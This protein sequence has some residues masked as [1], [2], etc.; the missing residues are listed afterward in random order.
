MN[1]KHKQLMLAFLA[2]A[3][4]TLA[5]TSS[6]FIIQ[7]QKLSNLIK[8]QDKLWKELNDFKVNNLSHDEFLTR[9]VQNIL[10]NNPVLNLFEDNFSKVQTKINNL[11]FALNKFKE[12]INKQKQLNFEKYKTLSQEVETYISKNLKY[13]EYEDLKKSLENIKLNTDRH[14]NYESTQQEIDEQVKILKEAFEK[15]KKD[16]AIKDNDIRQIAYADYEMELRKLN[17]FIKNPLAQHEFYKE[18]YDSEIINRD[19]ITKDIDLNTSSVGDILEAKYKLIKELE[20]A[21]KKAHKVSKQELQ[22]TYDKAIKYANGTLI[23]PDDENTKNLL[24]NNAKEKHDSGMETD[25]FNII[26]ENI[27]SILN[28][29]EAAKIEKQVNDTFR[30]NATNSL[31]TAIKLAEDFIE[32]FS[33]GKY[34]EIKKYVLDILETET[35]DINPKTFDQI[36]ESGNKIVDALEAKKTEAIASYDAQVKKINEIKNELSIR[37]YYSIRNEISQLINDQKTIR[38]DKNSTTRQILDLTEALKNYEAKIKNKKEAKLGID[39]IL[40]EIEEYI[41]QNNHPEDKSSIAKLQTKLNETKSAIENLTKASELQKFSNEL[42]TKFEEIKQKIE[43]TKE[44]RESENNSYNQVVNLVNNLL[45]KLDS[46]NNYLDLKQQLSTTKT[47]TDGVVAK[48]DAISTS[49]QIKEAKDKLETKLNE[50]DSKKDQ[51]DL[52]E[53]T[54]EYNKRVAE[55]ETYKNSLDDKHSVIKQNLESKINKIKA[56]L[57]TIIDNNKETK[58][59]K[60]KATQQASS[61]IQEA[62]NKA[63]E[64]KEKTNKNRKFREFETLKNAINDY[65]DINLANNNDFDFIKDP[66]TKSVK[67]ESKLVEKDPNADLLQLKDK[68]EVEDIQK[69]I[70]KLNEIFNTS[71]DLK[72]SKDNYDNQVKSAE[73]KLSEIQKPI[74]NKDDEELYNT[75]KNKVTELQKFFEDDNNKTKENFDSKAQELSKA[76]TKTTEEYST[77]KAKRDQAKVKLEDKIKEIEDYVKNNLQE[78]KNGTFVTKPEHEDSVSRI[79]LK[80]QIAKGVKE[81]SSSTEQQL[82][83]ALNELIKEQEILNESVK[84]DNTAKQATEFLITLDKDL[85]A[86]I[87]NLQRSL[88][89]DLKVNLDSAIELQKSNKTKQDVTQKSI[90][91]AKEDLTNALNDAKNKEFNIFQNAYDNLSKKASELL[92]KLDETNVEDINKHTQYPEIAKALKEIKDQEDAKALSNS[93]PTIEIIKESLPKLQQAYD[94]AI[95]AKSKSDFDKVYEDILNKFIDNKNTSKYEKVKESVISKLKAQKDIRDKENPVS[96]SQEIDNATEIIKSQIP[97]LNSIK[98]KFDEYI[99]KYNKV[100]DYKKKLSDDQEEAKK[101]LADALETYKQS[102]ISNDDILNPE[103]YKEFKDKLQEAI[104]NAKI[105]ETSKNNYKTEKDSIVADS[106]FN[107]YPKSL[108]KYKDAVDKITGEN[109]SLKQALAAAKT[110][111]EIKQAY[112]DAK[113][114][115]KQAKNDIALNKAEENYLNIVDKIDEF[116]KQLNSKDTNEK[117]IID[118]LDKAKKDAKEAINNKTS[119]N[120]SSITTKDYNTQKQ[121][122][123]EA[124]LKAQLDKSKNDFKKTKQQAQATSNELEGNYPETKAY[125]DNKLSEIDGELTT[126]LTEAGK[127]IQKQKESYDTAKKAIE[128][129]N[130]TLDTKKHAELEK[131]KTEYEKS[132]TKFNEINEQINDIKDDDLKQKYTKEFKEAKSE[133]DKTLVDPKTPVKYAKAKEIL[134]AASESIKEYN[135]YEKLSKEVG[136]YVNQTL[137]NPNYKDL[138][139]ELAIAKN[140]QDNVALPEHNPTI[141]QVESSFDTLNEKYNEVK[142]SILRRN[143]VIHQ[144]TTAKTVFNSTKTE[145]TKIFGDL[146]TINKVIEF[147]DSNSLT[148]DNKLSE[149]MQ[150]HSHT[151]KTL[152][153]QTFI[154]ARNSYSKLQ[155]DS[156][157]ELRKQ[158]IAVIDEILNEPENERIDESKEEYKNLDYLK[159]KISAVDYEKSNYQT[160]IKS[161]YNDVQQNLQKINDNKKEYEKEHALALENLNKQNE[162]KNSLV[163]AK[164]TLIDAPDTWGRSLKYVNSKVNNTQSDKYLLKKDKQQFEGE[165]TAVNNKINFLQTLINKK[166]IK[167]NQTAKNYSSKSNLNLEENLNSLVEDVKKFIEITEMNNNENGYKNRTDNH[168]QI[169]DVQR[170]DET[171]N[172]YSDLT[173]KFIAKYEKQNKQSLT[174]SDYVNYRNLFFNSVKY[175]EQ[176]MD[177]LKNKLKLYVGYNE[178]NKPGLYVQK[179]RKLYGYLPLLASYKVWSKRL[180]G[181][182]SHLYKAVNA[183]MNFDDFSIPKPENKHENLT[184]SYLKKLI[185]DLQKSDDDSSDKKVEE[186][187]EQFIKE[188][189]SKA[190]NLIS[191]W[192]NG[193]DIGH[194]SQYYWKNYRWN[195]LRFKGDSQHYV[196]NEYVRKMIYSLLY[197]LPKNIENTDLYIKIKQQTDNL[198]RTYDQN[199]DNSHHTDFWTHQTKINNAIETYFELIDKYYDSSNTKEYKQLLLWDAKGGEAK[200]TNIATTVDYYADYNDGKYGFR[201]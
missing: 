105:V 60:I 104:N 153:D 22:I 64:E 32:S 135:K 118:V 144:L 59:E 119:T 196:F 2:I 201:L 85:N 190:G 46:K 186:N 151:N 175:Y 148:I 102:N 25:D 192:Y 74:L 94:A 37:N 197:K 8:E 143:V 69:S 195:Y 14:V 99:N 11:K 78:N 36:Y 10:D 13:K 86:N 181:F 194:Y 128:N 159:T 183:Y 35:K 189:K 182:Y 56:D 82:K 178:Q 154:E 136:D 1:R 52:D 87:T 27:N 168:I 42:N 110:T 76:I 146:K 100:S 140:T 184:F 89:S 4:T 20:D 120:P 157:N 96:T 112:E 65:I 57:Q 38:N 84:F 17:D 95:L 7:E 58:K 90:N 18:L 132:L 15:T 149:A 29:I 164:N 173:E 9:I 198:V 48:K 63:K 188:I 66:L 41:K 158:I 62:L 134:A 80:L 141:N 54:K 70:N 108:Q 107:N 39:K 160:N 47:E 73:D 103:K 172:L 24:L 191:N 12:M 55:A 111:Q 81:S 43:Q 167:S 19:Q 162:Y 124:L 174:A 152:N 53:A 166:S 31:E 77:N 155:K 171:K 200:N 26:Y 72:N 92:N 30:N 75:L 185:W 113:E 176:E 50:I 165:I 51:I 170:I 130:K 117:A 28:Y 115:L 91:Q 131:N 121:T 193:W 33:D 79:L 125:Y 23:T 147:M 161:I 83:D 179:F 139:L 180:D 106:E 137:N 156:Y 126:S 123:E 97:Q 61:D 5:A 199:P 67:D 114:A 122:L 133:A 142:T 45:K 6:T 16:K 93:K 177:L 3:T 49:D 145:I 138:N 129:L 116:K 101:I 88:I 98:D 169:K 187:I 44:K 68:I 71:K 127:D 150:N 34:P 163:N 40:E 21:T 109:G